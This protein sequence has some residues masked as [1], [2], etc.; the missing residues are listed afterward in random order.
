MGVNADDPDPSFMVHSPVSV[1]SDLWV[2]VIGPLNVLDELVNTINKFHSPVSDGGFSFS[3]EIRN[4]T[5]IKRAV[6]FFIV[7]I[8]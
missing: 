7:L 2:M 6:S 3:H 1:L 4:T 8:Y 5:A